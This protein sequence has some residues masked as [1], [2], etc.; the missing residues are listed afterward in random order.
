MDVSVSSELFSHLD[1]V[2]GGSLEE[3][4]E[5]VGCRSGFFMVCWRIEGLVKLRVLWS[6]ENGSSH[7][8]RPFLRTLGCLKCGK[9][10]ED[11]VNRSVM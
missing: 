3:L 7:F 11:F 2:A 8:N 1:W 6:K 10:F 9:M 5:V 4:R